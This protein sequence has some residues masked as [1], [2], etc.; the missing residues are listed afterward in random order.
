MLGALPANCDMTA[1]LHL[2]ASLC[3]PLGPRQM[4]RNGRQY[5]KTNY[6]WDV[7]MQKYEGLMAALK[8]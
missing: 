8:A 4:G 3:A 1:R 5:V 2:Q 6:R 7:I